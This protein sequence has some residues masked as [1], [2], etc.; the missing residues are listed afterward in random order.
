MQPAGLVVF[1]ANQNLPPAPG[2]GLLQ[3][4]RGKAL[5]SLPGA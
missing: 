4:R 3:G 1:A 5:G 2:R